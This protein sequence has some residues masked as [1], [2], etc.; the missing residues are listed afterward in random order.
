VDAVWLIVRNGNERAR[1]VYSKL[2]FAPFEPAPEVAALYDRVNEAPA[3][4][5]FRMR[6]GRGDWPPAERR[7]ERPPG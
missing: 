2:G 1:A 4:Q 7:K 5:C 3:E 6:L